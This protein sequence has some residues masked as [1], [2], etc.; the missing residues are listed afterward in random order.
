MLKPIPQILDGTLAILERI[1]TLLKGITNDSEKNAS[2][3]KISDRND[4][5]DASSSSDGNTI[6]SEEHFDASKSRR[7]ILKR[8]PTI[9]KRVLPIL[10]EIKGFS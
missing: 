2:A 3:S 1:L 9:V 6:D 10:K 8:I 7:T 4:N 5:S